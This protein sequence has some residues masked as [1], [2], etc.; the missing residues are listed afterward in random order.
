MP[1]PPEGHEN[2]RKDV[3]KVRLQF[4]HYIFAIL[5]SLLL[6]Y[7]IFSDRQTDPLSER[8][9]E[10]K[11]GVWHSTKISGISERKIKVK[12]VL[13]KFPQNPKIA[14]FFNCQPF[15]QNSGSRPGSPI[16]QFSVK[17]KASHA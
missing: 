8:G 7:I 1:C 5:S 14:E 9:G 10:E 3:I 15:N 6:F 16:P 2:S 4:F 11:S 12:K 13:R 17:W